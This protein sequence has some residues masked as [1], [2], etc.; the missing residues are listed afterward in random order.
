MTPGGVHVG[1][2]VDGSPVD[3]LGSQVL[4]RAE[5]GVR[6]GEVEPVAGLG[7]AEVGDQDTTVG[8]QQHVRGLDVAVHDA[9]LV[10]AGERVGDLGDDG[11]GL[12]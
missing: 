5:G 3:L 1:A 7:D 4:R 11:G 2:G 9:G 8:G 10:G 12:G 6:P